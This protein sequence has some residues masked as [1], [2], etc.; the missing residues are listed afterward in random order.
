MTKKELHEK[1][2][3]IF[4]VDKESS[5]SV[6]TNA[7]YSYPM[8]QV[9]F[10][11]SKS[12]Y[13]VT[14]ED[15][16]SSEWLIAVHV[17][18]ASFSTY[19][20][21]R[22]MSVLLTTPISVNFIYQR[23]NFKAKKSTKN[24]QKIVRALEVLQDKNIINLVS[25]YNDSVDLSDYNNVFIAKQS[26]TVSKIEIKTD[27]KGN[28]VE[29]ETTERTHL[30]FYQD[31]FIA[32]TKVNSDSKMIELIATYAS[33][34][35][36]F[37]SRDA[38]E[39]KN[40][41]LSFVNMNF[42]RPYLTFDGLEK[43]SSRMSISSKTASK[44]IEEL[45]DMNLIFAVKVKHPEVHEK[46]TYVRFEE[47]EMMRIYYENMIDCASNDK[48]EQLIDI[49]HAYESDSAEATKDS[50]ES[51][52]TSSEPVSETTQ[53]IMSD[54]TE[55][56]HESNVEAVEPTQI[57]EEDDDAVID[58]DAHVDVH[59]THVDDNDDS[60]L[61]QIERG[62]AFINLNVSILER[63]KTEEELLWEEY[64]AS[65]FN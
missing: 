45:V 21:N 51:T 8:S 12:G 60:D 36:N 6:F 10:V 30:L 57:D 4:E 43:I 48:Y 2:T 34:A 47:K 55:T 7:G 62:K 5:D 24:N 22:K 41:A 27:N 54:N 38:S 23:F 11:N 53:T 3:R 52:Q 61:A 20:F 50:S 33:L 14:K 39:Y 28:R 56:A 26:L 42:A 58:N 18:I 13:S 63:Q 15:G 32:I 65:L 49:K 1:V 31:A 59:V 46:H 64:E 35:T 17:A 44:R 29:Y 25:V 19:S 40:E 37:N 16:I 9:G